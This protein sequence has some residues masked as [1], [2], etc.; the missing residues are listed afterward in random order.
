MWCLQ[1]R[2][3]KVR[4]GKASAFVICGIFSV[5]SRCSFQVTHIFS[6]FHDLPRIKLYAS[7]PAAVVGRALDMADSSHVSE[8]RQDVVDDSRLADV[9][10]DSPE[11]IHSEPL[12]SRP[13]FPR[14]SNLERAAQASE[15]IEAKDH[16]LSA[17]LANQLKPGASN[18]TSMSH[19]DPE[20]GFAHI[21]GEIGG[22]GYNE[23]TVD[24]VPVPCPGADPV[25]TWTRDPL[26]EDYFGN[27]ADD[28]LMSQ[29]AVKQ[30]A[31]DAILSPGIGSHFS[32]AAH[33]WVRQGIRRYANNARVML[34]RHRE[35][36]DSTTIDG[37]ARDLLECV[38]RRREDG[39]QNRPLFFI[40]HSI[41][42]LVV[43][44]AL[45]FA[46][47]D[48][49]YRGI[50]YNCYGV[51]FFG[52]HRTPPSSLIVKLTYTATPHR[53]SSYLSMYSLS[54]SIQTLL[55]LQRPLPRYLSKELRVGSKS[56]DKLHEEFTDIASELRIWSFYETID[57]LLSGSGLG[58]HSEVKFTAP[59]VSIKSAIVGLRQEVIY[60]SLESDHAHCA[61]FGITNPRTLDT[62]LRD[63]SNSISKAASL[64]Q[65]RHTP[66]KLKEHVK[67][68]ITGFYQ[69]HGA[70]MDPS[71]P[72][73]RLYITRYHLK[74]F[75]EKGPEVCLDE[76]LR[77]VPRHAGYAG[78]RVSSSHQPARGGGGLN[79]LG[80]VQEF[81]KSALSRS[82]HGGRPSSPKP[83]IVIDS[84]IGQPDSGEDQAANRPT[85]IIHSLTLPT[86][87][88]SGLHRPSS[89]SSNGTASTMSEP[90]GL[91]IS[92]RGHSS[93]AS[94]QHE[95]HSEQDL[96]RL[97]SE[98]KS[99]N[100][101]EVTDQRIETLDFPAGFSRPEPK[102]RKFM[103]IHLPFTNPLWVRVRCVVYFLK[104]TRH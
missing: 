32:K 22:S 43:K 27:P 37:L 24:I 23:T 13:S 76:R 70:A 31:G 59:L 2:R 74:D 18:R 87:A 88:T 97:K 21:D 35:I 15:W 89:R 54:G 26:P 64:S 57:S 20:P 5:C 7:A 63:F 85:R 90:T 73:M 14:G 83:E 39:N 41:G 9:L 58:E 45:V 11:R 16:R 48:E 95:H 34:Y 68:E 94:H 62:Y 33:L 84:P 55:H 72:D 81:W 104:S 28:D 29:P 103:W 38:L 47:Q 53:G 3:G 93:R 96:K 69:D 80:N 30:L 66:L 17:D 56:L 60:S 67:V 25:E 102:Q 8:D 10:D 49:R 36:T 71:E 82:Y 79:I 91:G 6:Q 44:R 100:E 101:S 51:T 86:L 99:N 46:S 98:T 61:S 77:R 40:A 75:L 42:G 1:S 50:L 52:M 78:H 4:Q 12:P 65:T 92:P 19:W